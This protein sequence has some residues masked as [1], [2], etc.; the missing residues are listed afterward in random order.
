MLQISVSATNICVGKS[1]L[2]SGC[3][4]PRSPLTLSQRKL[5][6]ST[7]SD[8]FEGMPAMLDVFGHDGN[9][10]FM[11]GICA[12]FVLF[13]DGN[14]GML[15]ADGHEGTMANMF[16][17]ICLFCLDISGNGAGSIFTDVFLF[18][19][20]CNEGNLLTD[21]AVSLMLAFLMDAIPLTLATVGQVGVRFTI[22]AALS[23]LW[24]SD[25]GKSTD[26]K[27]GVL[28]LFGQEGPKFTIPVIISLCSS[29]MFTGKTCN[30]FD[31]FS[32]NLLFSTENF[33]NPKSALVICEDGNPGILL[34]VGHD[35]TRAVMLPDLQDKEH[36]H[37]KFICEIFQPHKICMPQKACCYVNALPHIQYITYVCLL[38]NKLHQAIIPINTTHVKPKSCALWTWRI[39]NI[40]PVV[41]HFWLLSQETFIN[42]GIPQ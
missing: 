7:G 30:S 14:P 13:A 5:G 8:N 15:E 26:G 33:S 38:G 19:G 2:F 10:D 39:K 16:F 35:G 9:R 21:Q 42:V 41:T 6:W 25:S 37:E 36:F 20:L 11:D 34:V 1:G 3:P 27:P 40:T 24:A 32:H 29:G 18:R 12:F 28:D 31:G 22:F 23:T 4:I 17:I